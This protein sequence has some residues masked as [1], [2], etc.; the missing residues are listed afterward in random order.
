MPSHA[1]PG[2]SL[3]SDSPKA[4]PPAGVDPQRWLSAPEREWGNADASGR[5]QGRSARWWRLRPGAPPAGASGTPVLVFADVFDARMTAW[6]GNDPR[7]RRLDRYDPSI[8]QPG[9]HDWIKLPL[10]PAQ[11]EAPVFVRVD[12]ARGVPIGVRLAG[13]DDVLADEIVRVRFHT[14]VHSALLLFGLVAAIYA[15]ALRQRYMLL[16]S[17]WCLGALVYLLV[18]SGEIAAMPGIEP[19]LP[20]AMRV[21]SLAVNV[22]TIL[23]YL[24][25]LR[26]LGLNDHH[27]KLARLIRGLLWLTVPLLIWHAL[28]I[29]SVVAAQSLNL[30]LVLLMVATTAGAL[31]RIRAGDENGWFYLATWAPVQLVMGARLFQFL[32]RQPTPAW[33]DHGFPLALAGASLI[34]VLATARAARLAEIDLRVA[35]ERARTDPLTGLPNRARLDASLSEQPRTGGRLAVLFVDLDHFKTINDRHGHDVGDHCLVTVA[36]VLRRIAGRFGVVARYGGEE[37]VVLLRDSAT[38]RAT[39][40]A[41]E[42]RRFIAEQ[43]VDV[44]PDVIRVT[45]SIGVAVSAPGE[46]PSEVVRRAD[47]A[48]YRAK[49]NGRNRV[50]IDPGGSTPSEIEPID[51]QPT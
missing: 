35:R 46:S 42:L 32:T 37:F 29:G 2:T 11:P 18:M 8:P 51:R 27:P 47:M 26:F 12:F 20:Q 14:F 43:P 7:P 49:R 41:E 48:L 33:L 40:L 44:R 3:S 31:L 6:V 22:S 24:F 13:L 4:S 36:E 16:L 10:D 21:A 38:E 23:A 30:A 9:A 15:V 50:E 25:L 39:E 5:I 28:S 1:R 34:L 19:L 17:G 45:A